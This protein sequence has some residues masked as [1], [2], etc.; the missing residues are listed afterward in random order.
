MRYAV[1]SNYF[2][3]LN[4]DWFKSQESLLSFLARPL[5]VKSKNVLI[6]LHYKGNYGDQFFVRYVTNML[7]N[8]QF[9]AN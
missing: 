1:F 5:H 9:R 2:F 7:L 8:A 3:L 6:Y 4:E